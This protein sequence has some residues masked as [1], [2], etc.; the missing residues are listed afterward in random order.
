MAHVAL[1]S[2][3]VSALLAGCLIPLSVSAGHASGVSEHDR[4][5]AAGPAQVHARTCPPTQERPL[6]LREAASRSLTEG[7]RIST[8]RV[9]GSGG[10]R[11]VRVESTPSAG[12]E[13]RPVG[14]A[15]WT[16][17]PQDIT[18]PS[19]ARALINAGFYPFA[20]DAALAGTVII[21]GTLQQGRD[22]SARHLVFVP[23]STPVSTR[24]TWHAHVRLASGHQL[25]VNA[26]NVSPSGRR[27]EGVIAYDATWRR[28]MMPAQASVILTDEGSRLVVPGLERAPNAGEILVQVFNDSWKTIP[29]ISF[30]PP[31]DLDWA[32]TGEKFP[33][34]ISTAMSVVPTGDLL[35]RNSRA[36]DCLI[37]DDRR[38]RSAVG[39]DS[40]GRIWLVVANSDSIDLDDGT[41]VGGATTR[42]MATWLESFGAETSVALDGGG[43]SAL[44]TS[45]GV[46]WRREDL[47]AS[48][49]TRRLHLAL[50]LTT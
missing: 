35:V 28:P 5:S 4:S 18:P 6:P 20:L 11:V 34:G 14:N 40:K 44:F 23:G 2:A 12:A 33:D 10:A 37:M 45:D 15:A 24:L 27:A 1:P 30:G 42:E 8:W 48:A 39:W 32:L 46:Q 19:S 9:K 47:P 7:V 50:A 3:S 41:R 22:I 43:G 36:R 17:S 29:A 16:V 49:F 13:L 21:D 38:L 26:Y 31:A 25:R